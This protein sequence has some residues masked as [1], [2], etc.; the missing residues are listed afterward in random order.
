[1]EL[2]K[3]LWK[4]MLFAYKRILLWYMQTDFHHWL[5]KEVIPYIRFT[6]YYTTLR[7]WKYKRGY[8]KLQPGHIIV[9]IDKKKLTTKLIG[10]TFTHAAL[11]VEKGV[12]WEVSEMTH[13]DYTESAFFDIC[14]EADRVVILRCKDWDE[15]YTRE[16]IKRCRSFRG[17][18]YDVEFKLGVKTLY[19]SE[20]VYQS[21]Y[22]HRLQVSLE[23]VAGIKRP[24]IS[25]T[26]IYKALNVEVIWD[27]DN[28]VR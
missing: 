14:K 12:E 15:Q 24:Y 23:D 22:E 1:M 9:G 25:P 10:G 17:T 20:L 3:S 28:E 26:G 2:L 16:V 27:S 8:R 4:C 13:T 6:T 19:C 21:D 5:L 7:G 11:C 18:D